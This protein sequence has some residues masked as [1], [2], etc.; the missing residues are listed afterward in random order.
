MTYL[1]PTYL[2]SDPT[3]AIKD[4]LAW[5]NII[6]AALICRPRMI[7]MGPSYQFVTL[8]TDI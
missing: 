8:A 4:N 3:Y 7:G 1:V 2:P 6:L 5:K